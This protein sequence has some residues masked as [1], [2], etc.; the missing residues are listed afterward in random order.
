MLA[1]RLGT[2]RM[3]SVGRGSYGCTHLKPKCKR[4]TLPGLRCSYRIGKMTDRLDMQSQLLPY[5]LPRSAHSFC[6]KVLPKTLSWLPEALAPPWQ[7]PI[8]VP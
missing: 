8:L 6:V 2:G 4:R 3:S 7:A 5:P 1:G